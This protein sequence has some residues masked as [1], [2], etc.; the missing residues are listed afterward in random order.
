MNF[1]APESQTIY[2]DTNRTVKVRKQIDQSNW[3]E[4]TTFMDSLGRTIKTVAKDSQ[5]DVIVE[6]HYS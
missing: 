6:T 2:D 5:G 4:A 3:D 1:T